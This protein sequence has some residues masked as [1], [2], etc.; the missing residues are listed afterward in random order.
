VRQDAL[1]EIVW[2]EIMRLLEDPTLIQAEIERRR[3]VARNADP[4][5]KRDAELRR[6]QARLEKNIERL[7]TAY[8][9]ELVTLPQLRQRMPQLRKQARAIESELQSLEMAAV[10]D[11]KYLQLA[12]SLATFRTKL[13]LRAETLEVR[14][15]QQVLRLVIKEVLVGH[16]TIRLRHSIPVPQS[17]PCGPGSNGSTAPTSGPF[18]AVPNPDYLLRQGSHLPLTG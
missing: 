17:G 10:D 14:E 15:R 1:D 3:E 6:E 7:V 13:R 4:L 11:A 9:E 18:V 2:H 12:E 5:R 8:Q 16:D